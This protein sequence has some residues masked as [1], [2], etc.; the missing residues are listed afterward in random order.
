MPSLFFRFRSRCR[1]GLCAAGFACAALLAGHPAAA[2]SP[3]PDYRFDV[4]VEP[5]EHIIEGTLLVRLPP[6]DPRSGGEWRFHLPPNRFAAVDPRGR[7]RDLDSV[8]FER[9]VSEDDVDP[10]LPAGFDPGGVEILSA[11][12][13]QGDLKV[14]TE[15]NDR[16]PQGYAAANGVLRVSAPDG[17]PLQAVTLRFRTRV[18][19][20][21]LDGWS[22][23]GLFLEHWHPSLANWK[24]GG[25]DLEPTAPRP[26]RFSGTIATNEAGWLAIGPG[27]VTRIEPGARLSLPDDLLP[28]HSLPIV[29]LRS[30]EGNVFSAGEGRGVSFFVS[31]GERLDRISRS[32]AERFLKFL[33]TDYQFEI[34]EMRPGAPGNLV[35]VQWDLPLGDLRTL[36]HIVLI[37][38]VHRHDDRILDRVY[39]AKLAR[40]IAQVWFGET[41]WADEDR[42]AWLPLG[43]SGFLAL[44]FFE[45]LWGWDGKVHTL[46]DWLN[47]RYREHFIEAPVRDLIYTNQDAPLLISLTRYPFRRT[48][49]VVAHNK[50]VLVLRTLSFV[51][52]KEAFRRAVTDL[53]REFRNQTATH[54]DFVG[55][56]SREAGQPLDW[57]FADWFE[58]TPRLDFDIDSWT[59]TPTENGYL[60]EVIVHRTGVSRMPIEVQATDV[61]GDKAVVRYDGRS[62]FGTVYLTLSAETA[63]I[64]L[65]PLE[66]LIETERRN[67]QSSPQIKFRPFYDWTKQSD[68][69]VTLQGTL[70]GNAIDGNYVGLGVSVP[71]NDTNSITAIPIY[72][73]RTQWTN[74][75]LT[76]NRAR[77]LLPRMNL[78]LSAT[79]LGGTTSQTAGVSYSFLTPDW[80]QASAGTVARLEHV[81][82]A[83]R[84]SGDEILSQD[85]GPA[86]NIGVNMSLGFLW[87]EAIRNGAGFSIEH[88]ES[89]LDSDFTYTRWDTSVSQSIRFS[90][91]HSVGLT[92]IRS[93]IE[94]QAPIQKQ[95]L[96]G[97]PGLLRGY[98]R[99]LNLV[100]DQSAGVRAEYNAAI[101]RGIWG[102]ALQVRKVST[103]FFADVAK[104]WDNNQTSDQV[105]QRQDVG[106]GLE[107][108]VSAIGVIEF[109]VRVDVAVPINDSQYHTPQVILFEALAF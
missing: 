51:A 39:T 106:I 71:I 80:L 90:P 89:G 48:A 81:E 108:R 97:G 40:A 52:G 59:E 85:G 11:Q 73:E 28:A 10:M 65:D 41:V 32:I 20:R 103:I 3:E 9:R 94:G 76:W 35:L 49:L 15:S 22:K 45:S 25:W 102:S 6:D 78:M 33:K 61:L 57:F 36:G 104:G 21:Y 27:L 77:F 14:E 1:L 79:K 101:A 31:G 30:S 75:E 62:E 63:S 64:R 93:G 87:S 56:V 105:P 5:K 95:I 34:P 84:P 55:I 26:A 83:V 42:E 46:A 43:M 23:S 67:N 60:V 53:Y 70:G 82:A 96:I 109:P 2:A 44:D 74:Y 18:P 19:Q 66:Y 88:S 54:S 86:N 91:N 58:G 38:A 7:R 12:D 72:G 16:I 98:P 99:T 68:V 37:P 92:L 47:P 69:L 17:R 50:S 107:I 100:N 8:P 24:D 29:F 13:A 4:Q